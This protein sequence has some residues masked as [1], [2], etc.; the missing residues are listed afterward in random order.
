MKPKAIRL[1]ALL[2]VVGSLFILLFPAP[3]KVKADS[4]WND[5][6]Q[7]VTIPYMSNDWLGG[8]SMTITGGRQDS[9]G[10]YTVEV[11]IA[12]A[13]GER[14]HG[15]ITNISIPDFAPQDGIT[16][17]YPRA[18]VSCADVYSYQFGNPDGG[19][20][21]D[22]S[23][24]AI[25][26]VGSPHVTLTWSNVYSCIPHPT[27]TP[28][29]SPTP[30]PP[31]V[32]PVGPIVPPGEPNP[33]TPIT[34]Q[35]TTCVYAPTGDVMLDT[36]RLVNW[37]LCNI[38]N[39]Y[40]CLLI[41]LLLKMWNTIINILRFMQAWREW[42]GNVVTQVTQWL[43]AN[44]LI[45]I[46]WLGGT[47]TNAVN[48]IVNG[49]SGNFRTTVI[50]SG[51][52]NLFDVL[53]SLFNN[54][55]N[56]GTTLIDGIRDV[57]SSVANVLISLIN[58]ILVLALLFAQIVIAVINL[59]ISAINEIFG[60]IGFVPRIVGTFL[61]AFGSAATNPI[62]GLSMFRTNSGTGSPGSLD[63]THPVLFHACLGLFVLDNT[64]F[65]SSINAGGIDIPIM[66]TIVL[67]MIGFIAI[68][69]VLWFIRKLRKAF[70]E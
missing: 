68:E 21:N 39:L 8:A 12:N 69:R 37:A 50:Q 4:I 43:I 5:G 48:A 64:V 31:A 53:I 45:C 46:Y 62:N 42:T 9:P 40:T 24:L 52:A 61:D 28:S 34:G 49:I 33:N 14:C 26:S 32:I 36:I 66:G 35:C 41:P 55:G 67:I 38:A 3:L 2:L 63:C 19:S 13:E 25:I 27:P 10:N 16:G 44:L 17:Y 6:C 57:V 54:I 60:L 1:T 15:T 58:A 30:L 56:L 59:L 11:Y 7:P 18:I 22:T 51:N 70:A 20:V 29:P 47:I 65:G 23:Y